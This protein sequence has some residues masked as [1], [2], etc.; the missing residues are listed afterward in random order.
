MRLV[1]GFGGKLETGGV[2]GADVTV[3]V[4]GGDGVENGGRKGELSAAE[5]AN[6]GDVRG[7]YTGTAGFSKKPEPR[8]GDHGRTDVKTFVL[9]NFGIFPQSGFVFHK[10]HIYMPTCRVPSPRYLT[11]VSELINSY[12]NAIVAM[13]VPKKGNFLIVKNVSHRNCRR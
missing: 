1:P 8:T 12:S 2:V 3:A 11:G 10:H 6:G 5:M 4:D 13:S 9:Q 7:V